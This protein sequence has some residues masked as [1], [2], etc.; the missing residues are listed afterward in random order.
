M[1][2]TNDLIVARATAIGFSSRQIVRVAGEGL[3]R[4]LLE[5]FDDLCGGLSRSKGPGSLLRVRLSEKSLGSQWGPLELDILYW[6]GESGPIGAPLAEIQLPHSMPLVDAVV[7]AI[8][9]KGG[10]IARGGEFTLRA[11]LA[12]RLDLVQAESILSVVDSQTPQQLTSALDR[13]AGGLGARL[14]QTRST[15]LNMAGDIEAMIDFSD[16]HADIA[17]HTEL[18]HRVENILGELQNV[19]LEFDVRDASATGSLPRVVLV[20]RSNIGKSSL[21]NAILGHNQSLVADEAFTTRDWLTATLSIHGVECTIVDS[22]GIDETFSTDSVKQE[23]RR[24]AIEQI[25]TADIILDCH[26]AYADVEEPCMEGHSARATVIRVRTRIDLAPEAGDVHQTNRP[27]HTRHNEIGVSIHSQESI[28]RIRRQIALSVSGQ[29]GGSG[30]ISQHLREGLAEAFVAMT[31][32]KVSLTIEH[33][34]AVVA[35]HLGR[36]ISAMAMVTGRVI[37]EEILDRMFSRHCIG[38]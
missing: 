8:C 26:D 28:D 18:L 3:S 15:I 4:V 36:A 24:Q 30:S 33:D 9:D 23:A 5:L 2:N 10:R 38:K 34:E 11:F 31:A 37:D 12:G 1:W 27:I 19:S 16:E 17:L 13:M 6:P 21:F 22:A 7:G 14:E 29:N 32:A 20:G 25:S 35:S